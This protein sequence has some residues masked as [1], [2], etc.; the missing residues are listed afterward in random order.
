MEAKSMILEGM[1]MGV[2]P[3]TDFNTQATIGVTLDLGYRTDN[4][5]FMTQSVKVLNASVS[6]FQS[7]LDTKIEVE[8]EGVTV[9]SYLNGNRANL[10]VKAKSATILA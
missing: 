4:G 9:S 10:S 2:S 8:L 6:E 7:Y 5:K 3:A 1:L